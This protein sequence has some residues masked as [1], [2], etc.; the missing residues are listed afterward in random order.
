VLAEPGAAV[1]ARDHDRLEAAARYLHAVGTPLVE[2]YEA[3]L[4]RLV[5]FGPEWISGPRSDPEREIGG[6]VDDVVNRRREG[7]VP[8]T[9]G[10][11]MLAGIATRHVLGLSALSHVLEDRG[12]QVRSVDTAAVA[13]AVATELSTPASD[14]SDLACVVVALPE[15]SDQDGL[16]ELYR[17]LRQLAPGARLVLAG[18]AAYG[19]PGLKRRLGVDLVCT[20]LTQV[21]QLLD[22]R[23]Q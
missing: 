9:R 23:R 3:L 8:P 11:V 16:R 6:F 5:D 17:Q 21:L 15:G 20:H 7:V 18:P 22:L 14:S 19:D 1:G 12:W 10:T 4:A 2:I 13:A